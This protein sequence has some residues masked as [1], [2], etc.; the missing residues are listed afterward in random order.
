MAV[1]YSPPKSIFVHGGQHRTGS[2]SLQLYLKDHTS[3]LAEQG[4]YVCRANDFAP[5]TAG[6]D[7]VNCFTLPHLMLR[8]ELLSPMRLNRTLPVITSGAA[9][10]ARV[11]ANLFLRSRP[12]PRIIISAEAF[13]FLRTPEERQAFDQVFGDMQLRTLLF[14][15]HPEAW[16][17][18]WES[19]LRKWGYPVEASGQ[20][21]FDLSP[22]SWMV[23]HQAIRSFFPSQTS[24]AS[25]EQVVQ[26]EGSVIP[27]F[28]RFLG[29]DPLDAPPWQAYLVNASQPPITHQVPLRLAPGRSKPRVAMVTSPTLGHLGRTRLVADQ[30]HSRGAEVEFLLAHTPRHKRYPP[31]VLG[32]DFSAQFLSLDGGSYADHLE[33]ALQTGG[34]DGVLIDLSPAGRVDTANL[35]AWPTFFLTNAFLV[36]P[37]YL[38]TV[39][40]EW[41]DREGQAVNAV[42]ASKGMPPIRQVADLYQATRLFLADP[43]A[44]AQSCSVLPSNAQVV[45]PCSWILEGELPANW[46]SWDRL[47]LFSMGSTGSALPAAQ[48]VQELKWLSGAQRC[49]YV[50]AQSEQAAAI[51]GI[52]LA[53]SWAP[54][55]QLIERS[56]LVVTQGGTGSTYQALSL[57]KPVATLPTHRN[58]SLLA[59]ILAGLGAA[60]ILDEQGR[61]G[62]FADTTLEQLHQNARVMQVEIARTQGPLTV[63]RAILEEL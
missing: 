33:A 43:F 24:F 55:K 30:L 51:P 22:A 50:G 37:P 14:L 3:F 42:R 38:P 31:Q 28:L 44:V 29:I 27:A 1:R 16:L 18:S 53:L 41:L 20:G 54:L 12:E 46:P 34:Y 56:V 15:R 52:D 4:F 5:Y 21:I 2:T 48:A 58:Q 8:P 49:V 57:G 36:A 39:Q 60:L 10:R 35:A 23:D 47:L 40:S 7:M 25:Y 17:Q 26:E 9:H 13:A 32:S 19:Q 45:G 61:P 11:Q 59:E 6:D 63:A 62:Q